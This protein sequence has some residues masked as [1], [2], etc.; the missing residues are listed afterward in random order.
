MALGRG[1]GGD[2]I[3]E[4][5]AAADVVRDRSS[6]IPLG[7]LAEGVSTGLDNKVH[8]KAVGGPGLG[9]APHR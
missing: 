4:G 5:G 8:C 7:D 3:V 9:M 6:R 2:V 1:E